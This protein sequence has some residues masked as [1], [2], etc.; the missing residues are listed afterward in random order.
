MEVELWKDI[1]GYNGLY[2]VSNLGRVKSLQRIIKRNDGHVKT[3]KERILKTSAAT[4]GYLHLNLY[5][6]GSSV[7]RNVHILVA[8]A[9]LNHKP[10]GHKKVVDHI[11]NL[12][13]DNR[14]CNLQIISQ[15]EN[16]SKNKVDCSSKYVGVS[17]Y[18]PSQ[19]YKAHIRINNKQVHLGYFEKELE[20]AKAY[21]NK[22]KE[23]AKSFES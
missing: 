8:E 2:Q 12:A 13:T 10:D 9:F 19:K 20:A 4:G 21:Q 15:R 6:K 18:Q 23:I 5:K 1:D 11:N 16:T 14:L 22:L 7:T 17:W 3:I